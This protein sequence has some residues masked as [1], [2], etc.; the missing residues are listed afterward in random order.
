MKNRVNAKDLAS[1]LV[2]TALGVTGTWWSFSYPMGTARQMG[3][4]YVPAI[5]FG[6]LTILGLVI[7][8][9][10]VRSGADPIERPAVLTVIAILGSIVVFA[11][12][13]ERLGFVLAIFGL[14]LLSTSV[15]TS[16]STVGRAALAVALATFC[17]LVFVLGLGLPILT[18]PEM[19]R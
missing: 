19:I 12:A 7:L 2:F 8:L 18:W 17:W 16:L 10:A 11:Y 9:K 6:I 3:P 14:V 1:G 15:G 13:I 5:V 4:G